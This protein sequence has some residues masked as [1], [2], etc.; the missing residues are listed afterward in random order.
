MPEDILQNDDGTVHH[1]ADAEGQ[2]AQGHHVEV[3]PAEID[4][5]KGSYY[6][7]GHG[8]RYDQCAAQAP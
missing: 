3:Q 4:K 8:Q 6:G 5:D 1:H 2:P 7:D